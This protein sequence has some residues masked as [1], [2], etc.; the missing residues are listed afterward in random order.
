MGKKLK[1]ATLHKFGV[2]VWFV[3]VDSSYEFAT[4]HRLLPDNSKHT[5][6]IDFTK[7]ASASVIQILQG[8]DP[9]D[10][11]AALSTLGVKVCRSFVVVF[12]IIIKIRAHLR[13]DLTWSFLL[14]V[15]PF[16]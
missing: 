16:S 13:S 9:K 15:L 10:L 4:I 2:K 7:P 14:S 8:I 12:F 3:L 6:R 11:A 1:S 5:E